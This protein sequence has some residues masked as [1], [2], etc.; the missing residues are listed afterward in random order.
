[1]SKKKILAVDDDSTALGALRQILAQKGYE[2]TTAGN[3]EDA[4]A[5]LADERTFDLVILDVAMPGMSGYDVCRTLRKEPR[6]QDLPVIFLTAKGLLMDMA[7]GEDAGSDLYLIKPVLATKLLN[8]VGDVPVR[9]QPA[10]QAAADA[11]GL[12]RGLLVLAILAGAAVPAAAQG[13]V[14][15]TRFDRAAAR[16][17]VQEVDRELSR[18]SES[19]NIDAFTALLD[20]DTVFVSESGPPARGRAA[21]RVK[22]ATFFDPAG[23]SLTWEPY[24]GEVGS[25]GDLG[26]TRGKFL[27]QGKDAAGKPVTD[28]GEYLS[29]WR[30]Q[31]DGAWRLVVDSSLPAADARVAP[32]K[33]APSRVDHRGRVGRPALLVGRDAG[34]AGRHRPR[35]GGGPRT[36]GGA[37]RA[38]RERRHVVDR[39]RGHHLRDRPEPVGVPLPL[40]RRNGWTSLASSWARRESR[41]SCCRR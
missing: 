24:E 27:F 32:V 1:M 41:R 7:E 37:R 2:V 4:L 26:Y 28:R 5:I 19:R 18:A 8:M 9:R 6:T 38:A 34:G 36:P 17:A 25:Q 39:R 11:A 22:W 14:S 23:P 29:V 30:K 10:G 40:H 3:G 21:V 13:G 31:P 16:R 20:T 15:A 35:G 33:G 12:M